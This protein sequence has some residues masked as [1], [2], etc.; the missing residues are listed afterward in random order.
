MKKTQK[1]NISGVVFNIDEDAYHCLD[2]YL[3]Q[4]SARFANLEEAQEIVS[5]IEQRIAEL[6]HEKGKSGE[7][8]VTIDDVNEVI[9]I[10]G[11][12]SDY[13]DTDA[14]QP[15]FKRKK[16]MYRDVD[17]S[18]IA[19]VCS[20]L[21]NYFNIDISIVRVLIVILSFIGFGTGLI[22]YGLLW[23]IIPPAI[24]PTQKLEMQGQEFNLGSIEHKIATKVNQVK[25]SSLFDKIINGLGK[26]VLMFGKFLYIILRAVLIIIGITLILTG[27]AFIVTLLV[28]LFHG[29]DIFSYNGLPLFNDISTVIMSH[30]TSVS[31]FVTLAITAFLVVFIPCVLIIYA[32]LRIIFRFKSSDK[33]LVLSSVAIWFVAAIV[34]GISVAL[35]AKDFA[36]ERKSITYVDNTAQIEN[37]HIV[38]LPL[39]ENTDINPH[40]ALTID[41][42]SLYTSD[43]GVKLYIEPELHIY[44]ANGDNIKVEIVK[45]ASGA[46][47]LIASENVERIDFDY[48]L[49]GD[50]LFLDQIF[51]LKDYSKFRGQEVDVYV[52]IPKGKGVSLNQ[53]SYNI[54]DYSWSVSSIYYNQK[55]NEINIMGKN[56]LNED[57]E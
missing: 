28:A 24:T 5:D 20:G 26:I 14:D 9:S 48:T 2:N 6:F 3:N 21:G 36:R 50:T 22:V 53:E 1:V 47:K 30:F 45:K 46:T 40:A 49:R 32:G 55:P 43:D 8:I 25:E 54:L 37:L 51:G 27:I 7:Y 33:A 38:T 31:M 16:R 15:S 41:D 10:L 19:G 39:P 57:E 13:S 34:F 52:Y 56:E 11:S 35:I 44:R 23:I 4:I 18:I 42:F 29:G 17:N 12:P